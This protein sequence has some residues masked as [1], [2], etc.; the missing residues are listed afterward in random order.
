VKPNAPEHREAQATAGQQPAPDR[1]AA[2]AKLEAAARGS[3]GGARGAAVRGG[4]PGQ[5]RPSHGLPV[6]EARRPVLPP[7]PAPPATPERPCWYWTGVAPSGLPPPRE[8]GRNRWTGGR[9]GTGTREALRPPSPQS[10]PAAVDP[11]ASV[12][13]ARRGVTAINRGYSSC[14]TAGAVWVG[15]VRQCRRLSR[16]LEAGPRADCAASDGRTEATPDGGAK[17]KILH[18]GPWVPG[19]RSWAYNVRTMSS[20]AGS[21]SVRSTT[22]TWALT[23]ASTRA[24]VVSSGLKASR[25]R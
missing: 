12:C 10:A 4:R 22:S 8:P 3:A 21:C 13:Q 1:G 19:A 14:R 15:V 17:V 23:S 2:G 7:T 11:W 24:A 5:P 9:H 16:L 6:R 25:C 18:E 20:I